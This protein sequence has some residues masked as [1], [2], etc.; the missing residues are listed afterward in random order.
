MAAVSIS[1]NKPAHYNVGHTLEKYYKYF[2]HSELNIYI[3]ADNRE[4][5]HGNIVNCR[6]SHSQEA[7]IWVEREI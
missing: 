6:N 5:A 4:T 1:D 2:L 3:V 7:A